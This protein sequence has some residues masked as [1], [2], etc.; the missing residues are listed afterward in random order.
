MIVSIHQPDYIPYLGLFYKVSCS[1]IFVFLDDAQYSNANVHDWN[2]I[3]TPQGEYKLKIP[4][5]YAFGDPIN[6]VRPKNELKWRE[7]HLRTLEMNY[8]RASHFSQ[9]FPQFS[10][11]LMADY[12][13]LAEL[14]MAISRWIFNGFEF[15]VEIL[16]SSE[17]GL[18]SL[19]EARVIDICL[20]LG[21]HKYISGHGAKAYQVE[22]NFNARGLTLAYTDFQPIEYTQLWNKQCG[23]LKNMS[24]LD[25]IFNCG[26][27]WQL[28]LEKMKP[29]KKNQ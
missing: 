26:F 11:L 10:D 21:G 1:D 22:A 16:R 18:H 6:Q 25:Y 8:A 29:I 23:F 3:K 12:A 4:V 19:R 20:Q 17:M 13:S 14:N 5:D 27:D 28:V 9:L 24:I 15:K 7:K 2:R